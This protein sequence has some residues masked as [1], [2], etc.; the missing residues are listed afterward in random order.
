MSVQTSYGF[1]TPKGVAGGL[2]DLSPYSMDSRLNGESGDA[3]KYGMGAVI[4]TTAGVDVKV[5]INTDTVAE[6]DGVVMTGYNTEMDITRAITIMPKATVGILKTGKA[7]V[8]IDDKSAPA[9][10]DQL[11]L[12]IAGDF[13]GCF[14]TAAAVTSESYTAIKVNGHFIGSKGTGYIAPAFVNANDAK[15]SADIAALDTRVTTIE[16]KPA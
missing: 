2:F 14:T 1:A 3:L 15:L 6:F 16:N 11:Y 5:P 10:G 12:I 9:Y 7:W 4:G 8:R 13:A